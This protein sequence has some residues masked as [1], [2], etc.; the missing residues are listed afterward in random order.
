[1]NDYL[2]EC[3]LVDNPLA[4]LRNFKIPFDCMTHLSCSIAN[5]NIYKYRAS[6]VDLKILQNILKWDLVLVISPRRI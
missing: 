4:M 3:L 2:D 1:M 6:L 5:I